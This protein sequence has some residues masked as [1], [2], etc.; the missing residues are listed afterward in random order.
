MSILSANTPFIIADIGSNHRGS[1]DIAI[2]QIEKAAECG[3]S[4]A[5]FQLYSHKEL[6]GF[7]GDTPH[8]LQ[9]SWFPELKQVCDEHNIRFMCTAFSPEGVGLVDP[10]VEVHKVASSDLKYVQLLD[11]VKETGKEW[12]V[13][14]GGAHLDEVRTVCRLFDPTAVLECVAAYP[15]LSDN[16]QLE[17][18]RTF[19]GE[20]FVGI[21]DH[22][23]PNALDWLNASTTAAALYRASVFEVHFD[24]TT[25]LQPTPDSVVSHNPQQLAHYIK[26]A[27]EAVANG[28]KT[29]KYGG[30]KCELDMLLKWRRRLIATRDISEGETLTWGENFGSYRSKTDDT[31]ALGPEMWSMVEGTP[32][33]RAV[34]QGGAI[35]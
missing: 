3:V 22:T 30:R 18:I 33:K 25:E 17:W 29:T 24:A 26:T 1:I 11:A 27:K 16:H 5:K 19:S 9:A 13:S 28:N 20:R 34:K 12:I 14:T 10:Y 2:R 15:S 35:Y 31:H 21:S 32:S 6:Y 23:D 4:A 8:T 7:D